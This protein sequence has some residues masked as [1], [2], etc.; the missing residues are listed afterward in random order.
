MARLTKDV[1][2]NLE[3]TVYKAVD[4]LVQSISESKSGYIR[5]LIINDLYERNLITDDM[6]VDILVGS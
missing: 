6:I 3:P 5:K 4:T 2:V 1:Q